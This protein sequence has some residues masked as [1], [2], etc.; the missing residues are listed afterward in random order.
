MVGAHVADRRAVEAE[1]DAN[2]DAFQRMLGDLMRD[3]AGQ[4]AL[5]R[6]GEVVGFFDSPIAAAKAGLAR[7]EDGLFSVQEVTDRVEHVGW[8]IDAVDR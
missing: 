2:F 7:F 5:M 4:H 1:V 6:S 8:L 3:H